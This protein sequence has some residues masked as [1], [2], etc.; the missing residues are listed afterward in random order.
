MAVRRALGSGRRDGGTRRGRPDTLRNS[1]FR[2]HCLPIPRRRAPAPRL[3]QKRLQLGHLRLGGFAGGG[4]L[5]GPD[6]RDAT[7]I[8]FLVVRQQVP[9]GHRIAQSQRPVPVHPRIQPQHFAAQGP[10]RQPPAPAA[11]RPDS[12]PRPAASPAAAAR[13][14]HP[15]GQGASTPPPPAT[16]TAP[17][18]RPGPPATCSATP[19][20]ARSPD[21]SVP[22][23]ACSSG[24]DPPPAWPPP[25]PRTRPAPPPPRDYLPRSTLNMSPPTYTSARSR[26]CL[27]SAGSR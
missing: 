9:S 14:A 26:K 20:P 24:A 16:R 5:P 1:R 13:T 21:P 22:P 8:V 17:V 25:S 6:F 19:P 18:S 3:V 11:G 15:S 2:T 27:R 4:L 23:T 10:A 12:H 7:T